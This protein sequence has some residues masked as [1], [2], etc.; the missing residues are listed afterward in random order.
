[1]QVSIYRLSDYRR[2][3]CFG[4]NF[5]PKQMRSIDLATPRIP[6]RCI[7]VKSTY[8]TDAGRHGTCRTSQHIAITVHGCV[9]DILSELIGCLYHFTDKYSLIAAIKLLPMKLI[10]TRLVKGAEEDTQSLVKSDMYQTFCS[11]I[12]FNCSAEPIWN[13]LTVQSIC[14]NHKHTHAGKDAF[15]DCNEV[16]K[17]CSQSRQNKVD[18]TY[19]RY[20]REVMFCV[21]VY[22]DIQSPYTSSPQ[23]TG[24]EGAQKR[25]ATEQSDLLQKAN[26]CVRHKNTSFC[27]DRAKNSSGRSDRHIT[28]DHIPYQN[29]DKKLAICPTVEI[30]RIAKIGIYL[31]IQN[32]KLNRSSHVP[33]VKATEDM[34]VSKLLNKSKSIANSQQSED[35]RGIL[36]R[37]A[38]HADICKCNP[39]QCDPSRGNECSCNP[40]EEVTSNLNKVTTPEKQKKPIEESKPLNSKLIS[41]HISVD[42]LSKNYIKGC[43]TGCCGNKS[44]AQPTFSSEKQENVQLQPKFEMNVSSENSSSVTEFLQSSGSAGLQNTKENIVEKEKNVMPN[45][46]R[47]S[48]MGTSNLMDDTVEEF[49]RATV[50]E[51]IINKSED[52][53]YEINKMSDQKQ[54]MV[55]LM[56]ENRRKNLLQQIPCLPVISSENQG[57][58]SRAEVNGDTTAAGSCIL[59]H[60]PGSIVPHAAGNMVL[61]LGGSIMHQTSNG[62][63]AFLA[64]LDD[65]SNI[66]SPSIEDLIASPLSQSQELSHSDK[67]GLNIIDNNLDAIGTPS[68][69]NDFPFSPPSMIEC[70]L[71]EDLNGLPSVPSNSSSIANKSMSRDDSLSHVNNNNVPTSNM[72]PGNIFTG[73]HSGPSLDAITQRELQ[74]YNSRVDNSAIYP[75]SLTSHENPHI[76]NNSSDSRNS[77]KNPNDTRNLKQIAE[78]QVSFSKTDISDSQVGSSCC[79]TVSSD[80]LQSSYKNN[81]TTSTCDHDSH[82]Q[83]QM[84][85]VQMSET[86]CK[87]IDCS[88][89]FQIGEN[90]RKLDRTSLKQCGLSGINEGS[91]CSSSASTSQNDVAISSSNTD[92][93]C[94]KKSNMQSTSAAVNCNNLLKTLRSMNCDNSGKKCSSQVT[95]SGLS[96]S[97]QNP[98]NHVCNQRSTSQC[99]HCSPKSR[100]CST[101]PG[102]S[103]KALK[104]PDGGNSCCYQLT[105]CANKL[106]MLRTML[107]RCECEH[108]RSAG[109]VD[110]QALLNDALN[111]WEFLPS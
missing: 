109:T 48:P 39:C 73:T 107:L 46:Q 24:Y 102:A 61:N 74:M 101:H 22:S 2:T 92:G 88:S 96:S 91:C 63:S 78:E 30:N 51:A 65:L 26:C 110:L 3:I 106:R 50:G 68:I 10:Y 111:D 80:S 104:K 29:K 6:A 100:F 38:A 20:V 4:A 76:I 15:R 44:E 54:E 64:Q 87:R 43:A 36:E 85:K 71:N 9:A 47:I 66:G 7:V 52:L 33:I 81:L 53:R 62:S 34:S 42:N 49:L 97:H 55:S 11:P 28:N 18:R 35:G 75:T 79:N 27:L 41:D 90:K 31:R 1:M 12:L 8:G 17:V 89:S 16:V 86:N 37:I 59:P 5:E 32:M 84:E 60:N 70:L 57:R 95:S 69:A 105:V 45:L 23:L 103:E 72:Y 99:G 13:L 58:R 14:R 67:T 94:G 56:E 93:C 40:I 83:L 77:N 21:G 108:E 82:T 19:L 98:I 25:S